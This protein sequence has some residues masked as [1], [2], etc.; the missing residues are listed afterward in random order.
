MGNAQ[1]EFHDRHEKDKDDEIIRCDLDDGICRISF[2]QR[3]PD[4][5]H[6]R[7]GSRA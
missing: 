4:E 1:K 7:T 6:G 3:A 2:C 5:D